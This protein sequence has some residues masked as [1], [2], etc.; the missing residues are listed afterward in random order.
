MTG[1]A[2]DPGI[3]EDLLYRWEY[4]YAANK[5]FAFSGTGNLKDAESEQI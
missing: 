1:I 2:D 4:Q 5:A 3:K